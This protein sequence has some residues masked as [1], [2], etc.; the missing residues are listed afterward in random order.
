MVVAP[1]LTVLVARYKKAVM[2]YTG[3][4]NLNSLQSLG[5]G[6]TAGCCS[7]LGNNPIDTVKTRMQGIH[8][9]QYKNTLDCVMSTLR[10]EGIRGFYKG[11]LARMGRVVPGQG[12][13]FMT[14]EKITQVI[15]AAV[16][17]DQEAKRS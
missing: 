12:V 5:G 3:A 6:M 9:N 10:N 1:R 17:R 15:E 11:A 4:D 7:V 13:L 2:N 8:A 14:Y 16:K